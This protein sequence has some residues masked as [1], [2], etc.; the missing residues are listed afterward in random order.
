MENMTAPTPEEMQ[1]LLEKAQRD[2]QEALAKLT[3]EERA[4]AELKAQKMI[5]DDAAA[6][7]ELL[8]SGA[9]IAAGIPSKGPAAPKF[10]PNCGAPAGGGKF[11]GYCG[12]PLMP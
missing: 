11:C 9:R 10:C 5:E 6:M 3:P 1:E 4:Q 7:Q 2:L 12:N 8:D